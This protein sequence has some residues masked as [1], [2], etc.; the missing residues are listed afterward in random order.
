MP[1]LALALVIFVLGC[2]RDRRGELGSE[3]ADC[4]ADKSCDRGL[5]CLSNVCVRPPG[6]D[7][8]ALAET[9]ASFDLGNYATVEE[10]A[11]VVARYKAA[12]ETEQI[13]KDEGECIDKASDKWAA[14]QCAPRLFPELASTSTADCGAVRA[15]IRASY[16]AQ[17]AAF[18]A[19]PQMKAWFDRTMEVVQES[20]EQDKWPTA[21][22]Q[23]I[24][25]SAPG[26]TDALQ[27]CN[28]AMPASLQQKLQQRMTDAMHAMPRP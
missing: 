19:N 3:R 16:G 26:G 11:P 15:K 1:R 23:C 8:A 2:A 4:R 20:C 6:A 12:C 14:A 28:T 21:V 25:G 17:G 5:V 18:D 24:L 13:T 22:K 27:A 10:R 7:C 9:L